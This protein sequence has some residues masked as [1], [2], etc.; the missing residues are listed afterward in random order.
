MKTALENN[1]KIICFCIY[2][3]A[4]VVLESVNFD[5]ITI[6]GEKANRYLCLNEKGELGVRVRIAVLEIP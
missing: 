5:R 4:R 6:R 3:T 2:S 1:L